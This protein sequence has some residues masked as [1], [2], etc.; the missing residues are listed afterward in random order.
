MDARGGGNVFSRLRASFKSISYTYMLWRNVFLSLCC[1][2]EDAEWQ[3]SQ[4]PTSVIGHTNGDE[5]L[6][7]PMLEV[8]TAFYYSFFF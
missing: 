5:G 1:T 8:T 6:A 7:Q 2:A 4:S 3:M